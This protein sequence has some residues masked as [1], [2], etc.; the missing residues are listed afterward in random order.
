MVHCKKKLRHSLIDQES[1]EVKI[2]EWK[3]KDPTIKIFFRPKVA[4]AD[5]NKELDGDEGDI[6]DENCSNDDCWGTFPS[7]SFLRAVEIDKK[8][9]ADTFSFYHSNILIL[10]LNNC[11]LEQLNSSYNISDIHNDYAEISRDAAI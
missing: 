4:N 11:T 9:H 8:E 10:T 1:L 5:D 2:Q 3:T 6:D 7:D